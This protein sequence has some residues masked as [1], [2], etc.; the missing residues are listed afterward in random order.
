[1]ALLPLLAAVAAQGADLPS[2]A[3]ALL[4]ALAAHDLAAARATL[5]QDALFIDR[6]GDS[7][8]SSLESFAARA[9]ARKT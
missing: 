9:A 4:S 2:P 1:M 6:R 3:A 7:G 8:E 5:S